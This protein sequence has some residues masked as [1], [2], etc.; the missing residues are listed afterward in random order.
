M[1][2]TEPSK[3]SA[4]R[5]PFL[6]SFLFSFLLSDLFFPFIFKLVNYLDALIQLE[7]NY[8]PQVFV[9]YI[10]TYSGQPCLA[11]A[12]KILIFKLTTF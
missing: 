12:V 7:D 4:T 2:N 10:R 5:P 8:D 1:L 6:P 9:F 3:D 11:N